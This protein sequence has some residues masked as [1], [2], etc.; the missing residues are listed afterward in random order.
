MDW[1]SDESP[2]VV[3]RAF[4]SGMVA[5]L[6]PNSDDLTSIRDAIVSCRRNRKFVKSREPMDLLPL[7]LGT[8]VISEKKFEEQLVDGR[9]VQL[10]WDG[11]VEEITAT[12]PTFRYP[13]LPR[14]QF[15]HRAGMS[16]RRHQVGGSPARSW[17]PAS[18]RSKYVLVYPR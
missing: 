6:A 12:R 5:S 8:C 17:S 11:V 3:D 16:Q 7:G 18:R 4:D 14:F 13:Q 15:A 10:P 9:G 2:K 1:Y